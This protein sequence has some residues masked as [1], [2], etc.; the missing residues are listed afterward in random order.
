MAKTKII[1]ACQICGYQSPKWLG[2][3]PDCNQWNSLVEGGESIGCWWCTDSDIKHLMGRDAQT[4]M[5]RP[6]F[7]LQQITVSA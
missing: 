5:K 6:A 3:C 1:Y 7:E 4:D 2:M